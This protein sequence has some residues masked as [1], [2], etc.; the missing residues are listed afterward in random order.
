[1]LLLYSGGFA[2]MLR[3]LMSTGNVF[4]SL[5]L[6]AIAIAMVGIHYPEMLSVMLG[7]ARELKLF[8]TS[9]GLDPRYNIWVELLLE[10]RQLLFMG[11]TIVAR[12]LLSMITGLFAMVL[13]RE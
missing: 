3:L 12:I 13:G 1:M 10:E 9:R 8:L 2:V 7:W 4:L 6:G 11:F 5:V